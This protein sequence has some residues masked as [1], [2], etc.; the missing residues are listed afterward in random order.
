ME[1]SART[2]PSVAATLP[3]V[4]FIAVYAPAVGHGFVKDDFG[5]IASNIAGNLSDVGSIFLRTS[6]FYR[7]LVGLTFAANYALFGLD[8]LGYGITNLCLA[9]VCAAAVYKLAHTCGLAWGSAVVASA[10]WL[11]NVHGINMAVLWISGRT[12][13]LLTGFSVLAADQLLRRRVW[14]AAIYLGAAL[15]SKE[16]AVVLP[17]VLTAWL[18]LL[19]PERDQAWRRYVLKWLMVSGG[20]LAVYLYVR[21]Q[22]GA[23]TPSTAPI[24]YQFVFDPRV[25]LRNV[26]EY[27]DRAA[28]VAVASVLLGAVSLSG[29]R[30]WGALRKYLRTDL[31]AAGIVWAVGG[32]CL[33]VFLPVR[34]S[35]Y[36]CFPSV[37]VC[38]VAAACLEALWP[39]ASEHRR[40]RTLCIAIVVTIAVGMIHRSRTGRWTEIADLTSEVLPVIERYSAQ[41]PAGASVVVYDDLSTRRNLSAAFGT[42]LNLA[43]E[44]RNH[45]QLNLWIEPPLPDAPLAGLSPPCRGCEALTLALRNGVLVR[46]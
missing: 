14:V 15:L 40:R 32:Y 2:L 27:L 28:T 30:P 37:G 12:A 3:F 45:R 34:S 35:L 39:L 44:L 7:P 5:W 33:T 46:R 8:P 6:G 13:L 1:S 21:Q 36:A 18:F 41:L 17:F 26:A 23:V 31:V 38:L 9:L 16:E 43:F 11:L 24:Y 4:V 25:V 10:F 20:V 42:A 22:L 19:Q 29:R